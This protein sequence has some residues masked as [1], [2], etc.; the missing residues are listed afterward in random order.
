MTL[1]QDHLGVWW[2]MYVLAL[3]RLKRGGLILCNEMPMSYNSIICKILGSIKTKQKILLYLHIC[4]TF[5]HKKVNVY[6]PIFHPRCDFSPEFWDVEIQKSLLFIIISVFDVLTFPYDFKCFKP[7]NSCQ[8]MIKG[9]DNSLISITTRF[10][11]VCLFVCLFVL[12]FFF[13]FVLCASASDG[14]CNKHNIDI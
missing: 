8:I 11:F 6:F 3:A 7:I 1:A 13:F 5:R 12:G 9:D 2:Y 4:R 14:S 10:F